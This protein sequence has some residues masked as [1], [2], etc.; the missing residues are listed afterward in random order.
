MKLG[1]LDLA[2]RERFHLAVLV[3]YRHAIGQRI[4][5]ALGPTFAAQRQVFETTSGFKFDEIEHL[6]L[7]LHNNDGKFPRTAATDSCGEWQRMGQAP[8]GEESA[9]RS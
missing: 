6:L 5:A 3:K 8:A 4:L 1:W 7:T 2:R 9:T